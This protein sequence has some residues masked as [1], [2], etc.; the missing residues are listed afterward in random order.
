MDDRIVGRIKKILLGGGLIRVD[1][2]MTFSTENGSA[3]KIIRRRTGDDEHVYTKVREGVLAVLLPGGWVLVGGNVPTQCMVSFLENLAA[4]E[5]K[6]YAE[7]DEFPIP[8]RAMI[9]LE[10]LLARNADPEFE[11][12]SRVNFR[13]EDG[14]EP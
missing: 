11:P 5:G 7:A 10:D 13:P 8:L 6:G 3:I 9:R 4:S 1:G 2:L 12:F 14:P